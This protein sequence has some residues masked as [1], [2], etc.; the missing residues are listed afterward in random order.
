MGITK[1]ILTEL[2][3]NALV[4]AQIEIFF[5]QMECYLQGGLQTAPLAVLCVWETDRVVAGDSPPLKLSASFHLQLFL[6][7]RDSLSH[8]GE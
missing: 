1:A 8:R 6:I 2:F 7:R 5:D 3:R 4:T